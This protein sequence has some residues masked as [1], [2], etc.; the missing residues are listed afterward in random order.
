MAKAK[1]FHSSL[2]MQELILRSLFLHLGTFSAA[3]VYFRKDIAALIKAIFTFKQSSAETKNTFLFLLLTTLISSILGLAIIW[4]IKHFSIYFQG[5]GKTLSILLSILLLMTAMRELRSKNEE[6]K[7]AESLKPGDGIMLGVAQGLAVLPG[8][9]RSGT[10]I[11]CLLMKRFDKTVSL[12]LS[13]LM[14][15]PIIFTGNILFNLRKAQCS[16]ENLVSLIVSFVVGLFFINLL[17]KIASK[18]N[19]GFFVACFALLV[20]SSAFF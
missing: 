11:A 9:S 16:P 14:S 7:K 13:F 18:V 6:K 20:L 8:L 15:L 17:F 4:G 19:F 2:N 10:T 1:L 12:R 5:S 3:L